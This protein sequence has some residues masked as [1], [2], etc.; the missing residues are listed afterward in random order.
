MPV[1]P[2]RLLQAEIDALLERFRVGAEKAA[3]VAAGVTNAEADFVPAAGGW[4]IR[5][6]ACHL[7]DSEL[8]GAHRLRLVIAEE[9][10][11][12]TAFDQDAWSA[13]L[14]YGERKLS[15]ALDSFRLLRS[16]N[17]DLLHDLPVEMFARTGRHAER[18]LVTLHDLLRIYTEHGE[19]HARQIQTVREKYREFRKGA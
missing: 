4:S 12:L 11:L 7:S 14:N 8:V 3:A 10:P 17:F 15:E 2:M 5:H 19:N 1:T 6:I 16:L 13:R 9:E 18:G